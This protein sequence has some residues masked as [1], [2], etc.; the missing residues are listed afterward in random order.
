[1]GVNQKLVISGDAI[2]IL[3]DPSSHNKM[4]VVRGSV[5]SCPVL[6]MWRT[7]TKSVTLTLAGT[8]L[9]SSTRIRSGSTIMTTGV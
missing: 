4:S 3:N 6:T 1:V 7:A 9:I 2:K 8:T 5:L